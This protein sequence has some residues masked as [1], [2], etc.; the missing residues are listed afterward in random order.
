MECVY[1]FDITGLL[2]AQV[3]TRVL[4]DREQKRLIYRRQ[5][6]FQSGVLAEAAVP[7]S[8]ATMLATKK[9]KV[10]KALKDL[11]ETRPAGALQVLMSQ[12]FRETL[13][14]HSYFS[15]PLDLFRQLPVK[16]MKVALTS[17]LSVK[18]RAAQPPGLLPL[19]KMQAMPLAERSALPLQDLSSPFLGALQDDLCALTDVGGGEVVPAVEPSFE[20]PHLL[21]ELVKS[22]EKD[23]LVVFRVADKNPI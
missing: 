11:Q 5:M 19:D 17:M 15:L 23:G 8:T 22:C 21:E 12:H 16:E 7:S 2:L 14:P 4:T 10:A 6:Q 1:S 20:N 13:N 3:P 9:S 18:G